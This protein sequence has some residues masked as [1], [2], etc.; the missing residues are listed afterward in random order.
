M[1]YT[2]FFKKKLKKNYTNGKKN[3][4]YALLFRLIGLNQQATKQRWRR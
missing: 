4:D 1:M 2:L 3:K